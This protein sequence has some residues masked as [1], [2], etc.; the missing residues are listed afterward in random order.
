MMFLENW[1]WN[2]ETNL[3][4]VGAGAARMTAALLGS[5]SDVR[6]EASLSTICTRPYTCSSQKVLGTGLPRLWRW[7]VQFIFCWLMLTGHTRVRL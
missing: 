7:R 4:V 1:R 3:L 5:S 2:L 6:K